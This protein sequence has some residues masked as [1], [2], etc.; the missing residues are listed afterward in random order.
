MDKI[1]LKQVEQFIA[2]LK[3]LNNEDLQDLQSGSLK[4]DFTKRYSKDKKATFDSFT[5]GQYVAEIEGM[6]TREDCIAYL[7]RIQLQRK[8]L[9]GILRYL[10]VSFTK[11]DKKDKLQGKIIE[12]T[13][14][15]KLRD[16]AII[17]K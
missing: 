10:G 2:F 6:Q 7:E 17:N 11:K 15:R 13:I 4:I 16:D 1:L 9:E 5:F 14:G 3:K 8:D 12:N